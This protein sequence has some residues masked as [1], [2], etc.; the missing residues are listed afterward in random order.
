[1]RTCAFAPS[2]VSSLAISL[3]LLSTTACSGGDKVDPKASAGT[4]AAPEKSA[5]ADGSAGEGAKAGGAEAAAA[6]SGPAAD[7]KTGDEAEGEGEDQAGGESGTGAAYDRAALEALAPVGVEFCDAYVDAYRKCII[8]TVPEGEK[9]GH[10]ATLMHEHE[11]W[12]RTKAG[13]AEVAA[14]ALE[15]GCRSAHAQAAQKTQALNCAWPS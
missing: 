11:N 8:F 7:P 1:M 15:I 6:A 4:A 14:E 10:A 9:A 13:A 3:V 2:W 5:A 12:A